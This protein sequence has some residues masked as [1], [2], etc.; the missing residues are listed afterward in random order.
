MLHKWCYD[1][2]KPLQNIE[3]VLFFS[4]NPQRL[5]HATLEQPW[6]STSKHS[7]KLC[8]MV[9]PME[10]FSFNMHDRKS[11]SV[12]SNVTLCCAIQE[13]SDAY[14][15]PADRLFLEWQPLPDLSFYEKGN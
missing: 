13:T 10:T 9:V 4:Q 2:I 12:E 15:L 3:E 6:C 8:N 11:L 7:G 1:R 5:R 14:C